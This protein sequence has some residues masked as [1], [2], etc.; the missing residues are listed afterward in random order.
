M[1]SQENTL[2][3]WK[4]LRAHRGGRVALSAGVIVLV[5]IAATQGWERLGERAQEKVA[6]AEIRKV[7]DTL[8]QMVAGAE[9]CAISKVKANGRPGAAM[10]PGHSTASGR[11]ARH[12]LTLNPLFAFIDVVKHADYSQAQ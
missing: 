1:N 6:T 8:S 11:L 12:L 9:G 10:P 2:S 5:A 4:R 7:A 3:P